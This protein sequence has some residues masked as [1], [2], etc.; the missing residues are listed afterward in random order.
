MKFNALSLGLV[1][2]LAVSSP[3][4]TTNEDANVANIAKRATITDVS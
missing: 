4:P 2:G 1:A 3:T